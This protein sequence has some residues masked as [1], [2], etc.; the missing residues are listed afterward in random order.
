M[1]LNH[2][3]YLKFDQKA[4]CNALDG[5]DKL[6]NN[7]EGGGL[8]WWQQM[9]RKVVLIIYSLTWLYLS[10]RLIEVY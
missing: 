9:K 7:N 4:I 1:N 10:K 2:F 5:P 3:D 6:L 8:K